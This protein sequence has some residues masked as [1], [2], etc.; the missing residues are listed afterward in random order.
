MMA[1]MIRSRARKYFAAAIALMMAL[2]L[3]AAGGSLGCGGNPVVTIPDTGLREAIE[4]TLN[5][6]PGDDIYASELAWIQ[7]LDA[8]AI[9]RRFLDSPV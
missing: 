4:E 7:Q 1:R 9:Y 2:G 5:K 6:L 3:C 8:T